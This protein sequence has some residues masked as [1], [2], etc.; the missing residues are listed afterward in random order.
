MRAPSICELDGVLI[1]PQVAAGRRQALGEQADERAGGGGRG[2]RTSPSQSR[3][4]RAA[5]DVGAP[6]P[7]SLLDELVELHHPVDQALRTRRA[8]G[9]V[10]VHR[11]DAIDALH[12]AVAALEAAA[13]GGAGAHGDAPLR[14]RHLLP[15]PHQRAGHLRGQRAGHDQDVGL[16]RAG[17]E[18]EHPEAVDVVHARRRAHHLDGAAATGRRA[19]ATA[20][21]RG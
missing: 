14:L 15:Q 1:G 5:V 13:R 20:S 4:L 3:A 7:A 21:W 18:R 16:A 2:Q 10:D 19:T 9:D 6:L 12:D 8:A 11:H 17:A